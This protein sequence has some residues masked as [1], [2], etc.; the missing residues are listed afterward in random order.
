MPDRYRRDSMPRPFLI[1]DEVKRMQGHCN[2]PDGPFQRSTQRQSRKGIRASRS[3]YGSFHGYCS[4]DVSPGLRDV[5]ARCGRR[6]AAIEEGAARRQGD[7]D[8]ERWCGEM[9]GRGRG[10][11]GTPSRRK[12]PREAGLR[13]NQRPTVCGATDHGCG[14]R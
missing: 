3:A 12:E 1:P 7:R 11:T 6:D 10:G 14:E 8:E 4:R 13:K 9:R 2:G 5:S